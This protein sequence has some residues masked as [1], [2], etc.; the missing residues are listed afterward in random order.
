MRNDSH[1]LP[2]PS[3]DHDDS[4]HDDAVLARQVAAMYLATPR[5]DAESVA[6]CAREVLAAQMHMPSRAVDGM[7]RPRWWWGAAAAV[8]L[9]AVSWTGARVSDR[10]TAHT[11]APEVLAVNE[12]PSGLVTELAGSDTVRFDL[13]LPATARAVAIVGDFN[14]WDA[15]ATPMLRRNGPNSWSAQVTLQP[16]RHVYAFVVDGTRWLVDP[17]APQVT[18][19]GFGRSNAV[20]VE[21]GTQ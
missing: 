14:D 3:S 8:F 20:I 4:D 9:A 21:G 11:E 7:L 17:L 2:F 12:G 6:R 15:R 5:A 18:D 19:T 10:R 1:L 16:G 13:K